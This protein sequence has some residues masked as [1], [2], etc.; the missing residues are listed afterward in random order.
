MKEANAFMI[1]LSFLLIFMAG[2][3]LGL[4][5]SLDMDRLDRIKKNIELRENLKK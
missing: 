2:Y 4:D 5:K 3:V 1:L